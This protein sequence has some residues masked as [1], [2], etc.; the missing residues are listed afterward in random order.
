MFAVIKYTG[1]IVL[2][3]E[4]KRTPPKE[5]K[6]G[7]AWE[8]AFL[9]KRFYPLHPTWNFR[10]REQPF[11]YEIRWDTCLPVFVYFTI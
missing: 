9:D 10:L 8:R 1:Q 6:H 5:I 3:F 4:S 11:V 2:V 7:F